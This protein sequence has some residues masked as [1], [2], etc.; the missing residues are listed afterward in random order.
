M[1]YWEHTKDRDQKTL[2]VWNQHAPTL[3]VGGLGPDDLADLIAQFEPAAQARTTAQ[4][5]HD[6]AV[7]GVKTALLKMK[8]LGTKVA[9]IVDAQVA[10]DSG[11]QDDL[12]DVF[13]IVPRSE[14]TILAR[15]R[16]LYPIWVRANAALAALP[17]PA[18]PITRP[19]Q[20]VP[21]TAAMLKALLD[22]YTDV[23]QTS[24]DKE[25][26]LNKKRGDLRTLN[27]KGDQLA[28][29]WYKV[30][31]NTFD[32]GTEE[33]LALDQIPTEQGT[34]LPDPIDLQPLEQGGEDGLHV[35][36]MTEAGGGDHATTREIE[37]MV[38]GVDADFGHTVPIDP[39]GNT[40]G[41]FTVGQVVKVRTKA[42]NST[43]TTTSA[44]RMITIAEPL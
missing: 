9:Q 38:E 14:P 17:T 31:K 21:Q 28:K 32:P 41:P 36:A 39:S 15:A 30:A 16:A 43:G 40:F 26:M 10:G 42:T 33:Y 4:D 22:G 8:I 6:E 23:T 35:L 34:P 27:R 20:G 7:R 3:T 44:V 29:N 1:E 11:I 19:I 25:A 24:D 37:Y 13:R 18:G 5:D 2:A 12:D